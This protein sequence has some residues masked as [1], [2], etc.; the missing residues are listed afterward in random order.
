MNP[1]LHEIS[2][3]MMPATGVLMGGMT[4]SFIALFCIWTWYAYAPSRSE[5]MESYGRL[6]FED[7][8]PR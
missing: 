2:S 1:V 8:E 6:P 5:L 4:A 3:S 7:G